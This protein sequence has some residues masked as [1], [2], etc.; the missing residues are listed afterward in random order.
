MTEA[1]VFGGASSVSVI[2]ASFKVLSQDNFHARIIREL[3][4]AIRPAELDMVND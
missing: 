3:D 2:A 4:C 1:A